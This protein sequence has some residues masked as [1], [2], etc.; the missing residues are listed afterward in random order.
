MYSHTP[1]L[2]QQ[3]L[4]FLDPKPGQNFIDATLGGGGY[5]EA[6]LKAVAPTGKV[7][8]IDL[9]RDA[10]VNS[11]NP[12]AVQGNFARL[13]SIVESHDFTDI[14][15]IVADIGLSSHQLD[16]SGR[17]LSFQKD[18]PLDMRFDLSSDGDD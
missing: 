15:G 1:V 18:E 5:T 9:D 11:N 12:L 17:G 4:Q 3:A 13:S 2:L 10:V 6:L 8:S 16:E 14:S 7:L